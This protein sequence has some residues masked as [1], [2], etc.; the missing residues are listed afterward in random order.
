ML[1]RRDLHRP[2]RDLEY[3]AFVFAGPRYRGV[4]EH[5]PTCG[6]DVSLHTTRSQWFSMPSR[7]WRPPILKV[8]GNTVTRLLLEFVLCSRDGMIP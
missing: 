5:E 4:E 3:G 8:C 6:A 7:R 1:Q 2:R